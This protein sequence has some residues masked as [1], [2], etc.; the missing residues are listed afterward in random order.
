MQ[1]ESTVEV[2]KMRLTWDDVKII[3]DFEGCMLDAYPD[4]ATGG[5]PWTIGFG[6]TRRLD[7]SEVKKGDK[8]TQLE[9]DK[10]LM[11]EVE[12]FESGVLKLVKVELNQNE[13]AALVSFSFNVGLG[14]LEKSTLLKLL[15]ENKKL[16]ASE[17]F[18]RWNK[19]N[20]KVMNGLTKRRLA[21]RSLFLSA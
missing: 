2:K 4:P 6:N 9:A 3:R 16:E 7:G 12:H 17:Q 14:N 5:N 10:L 8:I 11:K 13:L 19:A 18:V 1:T 21:E 20:G 15:N